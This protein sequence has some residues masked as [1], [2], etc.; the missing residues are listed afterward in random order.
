[1]TVAV[2]QDLRPLLGPARDQ[3]QRPTCLAFAASDTH[4][5]LRSPPTTLSAEFAFYHAQRRAGRPPTAGANLS[6]MLAALKGDGQPVEADWPYLNALPSDL[7]TYGPPADLK[8]FR[9]NGEP[10]PGGVDEIVLQL[11][12]KRPVLTLLMLS[13]AFYMPDRDGVVATT[14]GEGP[15]PQRRHAVVAVGH[16]TRAGERVILVRNSWGLGWGLAG[17]AWLTESF[18]TPRLTRVA[19]LTEEIHVPAQTLAA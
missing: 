19:L 8:V 4:A 16:G 18:I 10:R 1:M 9:R 6:H 15:D 17:H 11:D 3:G 2:Q 5:A 13:D 14:P 7:D 12:A